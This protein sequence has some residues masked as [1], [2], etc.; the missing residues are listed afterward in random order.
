MQ[1]ISN[2][3]IVGSN[4]A[5]GLKVFNSQSLATPAKQENN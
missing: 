5:Q 4:T 1:I 2:D 3:K